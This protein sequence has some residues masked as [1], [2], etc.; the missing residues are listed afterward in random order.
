[1]S[2]SHPTRVLLIDDNP[3]RA[4]TIKQ[5]L[6]ACWH[7]CVEVQVAATPQAALNLSARESFD[8]IMQSYGSCRDCASNVLTQ[9][10]A[11]LRVIIVDREFQ[12]LPEGTH[13]QIVVPE[14]IPPRDSG[15]IHD[16]RAFMGACPPLSLALANRDR[17]SP[18]VKLQIRWLDPRGDYEKGKQ[19]LIELVSQLLPPVGQ[20]EVHP[21]GQG[22][23]GAKV[24]CISCAAAGRAINRALKLTP[25]ASYQAWKYEHERKHYRDIWDQLGGDVLALMPAIYN[26]T[27]DDDGKPR[28]VRSE[29]WLAMLSTLHAGNRLCVAD[30]EEVFLNPDAQIANMRAIVPSHV[31]LPADRN[32]LPGFFLDRLL[33][34]LEGW[35]NRTCKD[36]GASRRTLWALSEPREDEPPAFPP[37]RFKAWERTRIIESIYA[38]DRYGPCL[39]PAQWT[40]CRNCV[41][42]CVPLGD[43]LVL[44]LRPFLEESPVLLSHVHGD[45][46]ARNVRMALSRG[47]PFLIDFA[48][49]QPAGHTVQD[50]ARLEV[51]IKVELMGLDK[52]GAPDAKDLDPAE[53]AK[54]CSA[55]RW[56]LTWPDNI[57]SL[58][59]D[60]CGDTYVKRAYTLCHDLRSHAK[61]MHDRLVAKAGA[62]WNPV[63]DFVRSYEAALLYHTLQ[64]I[65][66]DSLPH[67]KRIFAAYSVNRII[68]RQPAV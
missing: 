48:C 38:L 28:V 40:T 67:V 68:E 65:R 37:Y 27:Q 64:A 21:L 31:T 6:E 42:G 7:V 3:A 35:Y 23:S 25:T 43:T 1:M 49:F 47:L 19:V 15:L 51:A 66:Y 30:F 17:L 11:R 59:I 20:F 18:E 24:F 2:P 62:A 29:N 57:G 58:P 8:I 52:A 63:P 34:E 50:C 13:A 10:T 9:R 5:T 36:P 53:F 22:F 61:A 16:L 54:W 33:T 44:Q 14:H 41:L 55:E 39:L 26:P 45:L 60:Q 4:D 56:L 32:T 12:Q 46:N